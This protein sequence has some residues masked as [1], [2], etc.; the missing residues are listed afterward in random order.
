[1]P[2]YACR[3]ATTIQALIGRASAAHDALAGVGEAVEDEWQ[4]IAD[5]QAIW[6]SRFREVVVAR[7]VEDVSPAAVAAVERAADE[8]GRI[9]DP[10]RAIDWLST[11]PAIVL[12]ALGERT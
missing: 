12:T 8:L 6:G 11:F 2:G 3:V 1:M 9:E 5:L 7:G 4:Y 10:H